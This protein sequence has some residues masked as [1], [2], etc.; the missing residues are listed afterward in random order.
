[1]ATYNRVAQGKSNKGRKLKSEETLVFI[2]RSGE[3]WPRKAPIPLKAFVGIQYERGAAVAALKKIFQ[4]LFTSVVDAANFF[5]TSLQEIIS[6]AELTRGMARCHI[7]NLETEHLLFDLDKRIVDGIRIRAFVEAFNWLETPIIVTPQSMAASRARMP[8]VEQR[9]AEIL[10]ENA[11][12]FNALDYM[13]PKER[14]STV[15]SAQQSQHFEQ[16]SWG[17]T[18]QSFQAAPPL[19]LKKVGRALNVREKYLLSHNQLESQQLPEWINELS[20]AYYG[21]KPPKAGKPKSDGKAKQA[22]DEA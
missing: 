11:A 13:K 10:R 20:D 12:G 1:M 22:F 16:R 4:Q 17:G 21:D 15:V 19:D 18:G 8:Q 7:R 9:V 2:N 3:R 6:A 5:G 14:S